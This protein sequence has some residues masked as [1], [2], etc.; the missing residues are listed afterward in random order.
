TRFADPFLDPRLGI[1]QR[2]AIVQHLQRA[3]GN[4]Y[5]QRLIT[6]ANERALGRAA[7]ADCGDDESVARVV[8]FPVPPGAT[9][10]GAGAVQREAVACP[11]PPAPAAPTA[12][13]QDPKFR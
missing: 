2:A 1:A 13:K 3:H 6:R 7:C 11:E 8:V 12:P 9:A 10:R 5:V 4:A